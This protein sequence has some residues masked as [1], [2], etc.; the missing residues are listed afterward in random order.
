MRGK[1]GR[2]FGNMY[3]GHR[4]KAKGGRIKGGRWGWLGWGGVVEGKMETTAFEQQ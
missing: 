4:D 3:K 2:V 1:Q